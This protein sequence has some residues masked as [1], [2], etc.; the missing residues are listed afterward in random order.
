MQVKINTNIVMDGSNWDDFTEEEKEERK[1]WKVEAEK[2]SK[3]VFYYIFE[4][5]SSQNFLLII[6]FS[7]NSMP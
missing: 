7:D 1:R 5:K 2:L 4:K 6:P 3:S